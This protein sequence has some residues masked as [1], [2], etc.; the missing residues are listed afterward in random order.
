M[1]V[2]EQANAGKESSEAL[3]DVSE[4]GQSRPFGNSKGDNRIAAEED[5]PSAEDCPRGGGQSSQG[6]LE[7]WREEMG[8][9]HGAGWL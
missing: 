6:A 3:G 9:F 8:A 4:G 2:H 5:Y 7:R 1:R